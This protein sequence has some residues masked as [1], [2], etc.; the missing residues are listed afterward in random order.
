MTKTLAARIPDELNDKV[1]KFAL[2][3]FNGNKSLVVINALTAYLEDYGSSDIENR[4]QKLENE[5]QE[6]REFIRGLIKLEKLGG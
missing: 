4:L 5:I 2:A 3:N 6:L 1:E